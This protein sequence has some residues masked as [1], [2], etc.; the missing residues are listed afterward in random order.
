M[1]ARLGRGASPAGAGPRASPPHSF[2]QPAPPLH[3]RVPTG[4]EVVFVAVDE[5]HPEVEEQ[6]DEQARALCQEDLGRGWRVTLEARGGET[7]GEEGLALTVTQLIWAPR[8]R[9]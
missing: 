6:V 4:R 5:G 2:S 1:Q 9:K 3:H 7:A 8:S